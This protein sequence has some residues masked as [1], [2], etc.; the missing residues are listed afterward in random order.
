MSLYSKLKCLQALKITISTRTTTTT[1]N[2]EKYTA[3]FW[4]NPQL[5]GGICYYYFFSPKCKSHSHKF[6]RRAAQ[7]RRSTKLLWELSC[8][9]QLQ[10]LI[11]FRKTQGKMQRKENTHKKSPKFLYGFFLNSLPAELAHLPNLSTAI[12]SAAYV[13]KGNFSFR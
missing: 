3:G 1:T 2:I 9:G 7:V 6:R 4:C 5:A 10:N 12:T 8:P 11:G 13:S